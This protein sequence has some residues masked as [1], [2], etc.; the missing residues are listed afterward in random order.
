MKTLIQSCNNSSSF[1]WLIFFRGEGKEASRVADSNQ[2]PVWVDPRG[3]CF[4][5]QTCVIPL[6]CCVK[7]C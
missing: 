7:S 4:R 1:F 3:D 2:I 6:L 5:T